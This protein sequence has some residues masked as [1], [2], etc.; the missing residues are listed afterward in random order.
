VRE[1]TGGEG[2]PVV[3]DSVGRATFSGS[4]DC[5]RSRGMLVCF[6][7]AS[8]KP[9]PFDT[10]LLGQ[11]GS[12]YLTRPSLFA[13]TETRD[14]LLASARALFEVVLA[15]TVKID[16]RQRWPLSEAAHAHRALESRQT[17]GATVLTVSS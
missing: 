9:D 15:G 12:L 16:V 13:Y 5:L 17:T 11:K 7:T 8:G 1:I 6:G 3:Y 4:L 14:E 2:V 10:A